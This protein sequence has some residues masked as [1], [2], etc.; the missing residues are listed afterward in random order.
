M[1]KHGNRRR[2]CW[3]GCH[4]LTKQLDR[5]I[6]PRKKLW[7]YWQRQTTFIHTDV[8][9]ASTGRQWHCYWMWKGSGLWTHRLGGS[10]WADCLFTF[11]PPSYQPA[12]LQQ[13][14]E[15]RENKK[16]GQGGRIFSSCGEKRDNRWLLELTFI[17]RKSQ[18]FI[19]I[20]LVSSI[21]TN[22]SDTWYM[23]ERPSSQRYCNSLSFY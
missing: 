19:L 2:K 11:S 8:S 5:E 17:I 21:Y 14:F 6:I 3:G 23:A 7:W 13:R 20:A 12:V 15:P 4:Q 10:D 18:S 22:M 9:A 16:G 1:Q